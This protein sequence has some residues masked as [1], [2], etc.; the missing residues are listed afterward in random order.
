MSTQLSRCGVPHIDVRSRIKVTFKDSKGNLIK[1]VEANEGD[2]ILDIAHEYDVDLEG[3]KPNL[4]P[5]HTRAHHPEY[6]ALPACPR[7]ARSSLGVQL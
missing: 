1:T 7:I 3:T 5:T 6:L 2:N 4:V